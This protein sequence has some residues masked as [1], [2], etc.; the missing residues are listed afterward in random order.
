LGDLTEAEI[1]D[2][3]KSN[4]RLAAQCCDD[5]ARLSKKGPTYRRLREHL[6]LIEGA[7][8]Q[9]AAWRSD[10]RWYRI[11]FMMG[12]AHKRAGNWLRG[13]KMPDGT[14]IATAA[15]HLNPL[16]TQLADNLRKGYAVAESFRTGKVNK[17]GMIL[18]K[19]LPGSH[20]D[21]RPIHV[22]SDSYAVRASGLIVPQ[23][24]ATA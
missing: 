15:G 6:K 17:L 18:P 3:L 10:A 22:S 13:T 12:E 16:F 2:C 8:K 21:T 4:F 20:R 11:A 1:F 14:R 5:L 7:C 19:P 9:A 24:E 23:S